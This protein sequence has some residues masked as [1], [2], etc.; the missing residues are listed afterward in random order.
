MKGNLNIQITKK[1]SWTQKHVW[2]D[3]ILRNYTFNTET[4]STL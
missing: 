1:M 2:M 3:S 4:N